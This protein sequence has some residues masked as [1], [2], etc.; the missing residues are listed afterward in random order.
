MLPLETSIAIAAAAAAVAAA[1][2]ANSSLPG[3]VLDRVV[4]NWITRLLLSIFSKRR[5]H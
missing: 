1:A 4:F 3:V 2:A 5:T